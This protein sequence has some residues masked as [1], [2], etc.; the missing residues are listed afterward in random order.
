[1]SDAQND[2]KDWSSAIVVLSLLGVGTALTVS[3]CQQQDRDL[4]RNEYQSL[5]ECK[6]DYR[7]NECEPYGPRFGYLGPSYYSNWRTQ[8]QGTFDNGGGPGRAALASPN[9]VVAHPTQTT[10]GGFGSTGRSYSGR[11]G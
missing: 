9:G 5:A 2:K 10:R 1:M 4:R 8:P 6:A 11:G 7:G 3:S